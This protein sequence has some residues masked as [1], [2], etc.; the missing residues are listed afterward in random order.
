MY[1]IPSKCKQV[2]CVRICVLTTRNHPL[3]G[4]FRFSTLDFVED[5]EI[6]ATVY[7]RLETRG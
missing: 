7:I 2:V 4:M 1:N 3:N 6:F 5:A